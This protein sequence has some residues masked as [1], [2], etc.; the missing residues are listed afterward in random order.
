MKLFSL[1]LTEDR[2]MENK[3]GIGRK[4]VKLTECNELDQYQ[5]LE[6]NNLKNNLKY[7]ESLLEKEQL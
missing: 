1:R 3:P 5:R 6:E 2:K 7:N 4:T